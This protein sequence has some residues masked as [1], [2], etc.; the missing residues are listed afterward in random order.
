MGVYVMKRIFYIIF[1]SIIVTGCSANTSTQI[2]T[3]LM[4]DNAQLVKIKDRT[5]IS[6]PSAD[7][8]AFINEFLEKHYNNKEIFNSYN[9]KEQ[10]IVLEAVEIIDKIKKE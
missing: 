9:E 1:L 4:D 10:R 8:K 5:T 2:D 7:D 3:E 6:E